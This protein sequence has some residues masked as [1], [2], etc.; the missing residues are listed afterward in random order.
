MGQFYAL[1]DH[2]ATQYYWYL[3]QVLLWATVLGISAWAMGWRVKE[4]L[5]SFLFVY[6][7][8]LI[9]FVIGQWKQ[10]GAYNLE[11]PLVA[12]VVGLVISNLL[13]LPTWMDAGFRV[14]YYIKTGIVLLGATLPFTLIIWAGPL[15]ML[16]ATIVSVV[17][18]A[19]IF[20]ASRSLGVD[21]RL[22][23]CLGAGGTICGVSGAIAMAGAVR[24]TKAQVAIAITLVIFW[25]I[26]M[27]FL[28]PFL[29]R[30]LQLHAA[31]A[32]A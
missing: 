29:S 5:A 22:C 24:A 19:V 7:A 15:A 23:A 27:I 12:L 3:L 21:R 11:P 30:A 18:F 17:T 8:S 25:A 16:Q 13:P 14:E 20:Y 31:V 28:L 32:G 9:I 10:A 26:V 6:T 2:F 4:F 1:R